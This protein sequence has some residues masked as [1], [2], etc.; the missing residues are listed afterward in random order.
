MRLRLATATVA[1]VAACGLFAA[2]ATA[3]T[4][5]VPNLPKPSWYTPELHQQVLDAGARGVAVGDERLN[6]ECPGVHV[7]GV[8]ASGCIVAPAGCTANFI[9]GGP[10]N[11]HI[12][13]AGH[14]VDGVGDE[15]VMQVDT[16]TLA[17]VG[18]VVRFVDNGV[19]DDFA[20]IRIDPGVAAKWGVTPALPVVG[21]PQ[22]VYTQC[23][24]VAVKHFGH[25]YGVAVAQ[26]K[27]SAGVATNWY[28]DGYGWTGFGLPGDSGSAVV[29]V[30][31]K[32]AGNLT[33]LGVDIG[34]YPG[35]DLFGTRA[36]RLIQIAGLPIVNANGTTSGGGATNC[37][38]GLGLRKL[39]RTLLR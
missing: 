12:G 7:G 22:G 8:Q 30:D 1:V 14:C 17:S 15:L 5:Q 24:P 16:A 21:G 27:P 31:G 9:F 19:G 28:D 18:T 6:T 33:H 34:Q 37:G 4:R 3:G 38:A 39:L 11:Y 29:T 25:G 2:S 23:G 20:L 13:T 36:T 10:G 35:S 26:G 32:A